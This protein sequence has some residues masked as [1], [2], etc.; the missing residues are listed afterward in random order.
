[1][2]PDE[3]VKA[4]T[5]EQP[6]GPDQPA[7]SARSRATPRMALDPGRESEMASLRWRFNSRRLLVALLTS[8]AIAGATCSTADAQQLAPPPPAPASSSIASFAPGP[9]SPGVYHLTLDD[10]RQLAIANNSQLQLGRLNVEE[11]QI[12]IRAAKTDYLPKILGSYAF[13]HFNDALGTVVTTPGIILGSKA[14]AVNVVNQNSSYGMIMAAQPITQLLG[15]SALVDIAR[16][17]ANT[18]AA[19]LDK[20]TADL[21]SGVTQAYT[22]L[23]IARKIQGALTLQ[24]SMVEPLLKQRPSAT[25]RLGLLEA[26]KGL[27][28]VSSQ[29]AELTD[30]LNQLLCLPPGT[31]LEVTEPALPM[32][33]VG[34]ADEAA[35]FALANNPQIC[36]AQQ[37]I[38]KAQAGMKAAKMDCL[39]IVAV[40]GGYVNQDIADYIQPNFGF[41]GVTAN[42]TLLDWGKRSYVMHQ[43][44]VQMMMANKNVQAT[45]ETVQLDA[46]KAY[47]AYTQAQGELQIA[48]EVVGA[49]LDGVKEAK[50]LPDVL[51]AKSAVA[52]AQLDQMKAE[53]A[54]RLAHIKLLAAIGQ[55]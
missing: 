49:S 25:L 1:M 30:T 21:V 18:A 4:I 5:A 16:A 23:V 42:Y 11:K 12:A 43:R 33:P 31:E 8:G 35:Q 54:F 38:L 47:L 27:A 26:R 50:D 10:A 9:A 44:E 7:E 14:I 15:V 29:T 24:I 2:W 32:V 40:V 6:F 37:N 55:R 19:Q 13:L 20:G 39:P 46:R 22:G 53:L 3:Y 34:S 41:V 17:D 48:N 28:E 45:S 36:E 52:K 51:T